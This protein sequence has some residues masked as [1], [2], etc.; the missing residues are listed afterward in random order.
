[1]SRA[2]ERDRSRVEKR[3]EGRGRKAES[4][5]RGPLAVERGK[6]RQALANVTKRNMKFPRS[7]RSL[8]KER[9]TDRNRRV[10]SP[11]SPIFSLLLAPSGTLSQKVQHLLSKEEP[12]EG[13]PPAVIK[14]RRPGPRYPADSLPA[15]EWPTVRQR[16]VEQKESLRTVAA[17]YDVSPETIRRLLLPTQKPHGQQEA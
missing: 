14:Q 15:S 6:G 11:L 12:A 2:G 4:L 9:G 1:L 13:S 7:E 10:S 16:V 5:E 3:S 17:A 8:G